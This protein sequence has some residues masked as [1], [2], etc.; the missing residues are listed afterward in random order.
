MA[1]RGRPPKPTA[2]RR[3]RNTDAIPGTRVAD[4]GL[5]RGPELPDGVDWHP[6]T[7][8]WWQTWRRSPLAQ[9]W[10]AT[11]WDFLLDTAMLHSRMWST[12]SL[13]L[14]AEVR[15]RVA[16]LGATTEDRARLRLSVQAPEM[17]A[18]ET[19]GTVAAIDEYR[20]R[21]TGRTD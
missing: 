12:G 20:R 15:L 7:V 2:E 11:D 16:K 14:A 8:A 21:L 18:A 10:F 17:D 4:D 6:Q 1:G 5:I 19:A 13:G 3:R 9:A